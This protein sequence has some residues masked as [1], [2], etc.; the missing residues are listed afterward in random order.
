ML[1]EARLGIEQ[2]FVDRC[3]ARAAAAP[4]CRRS[5]PG[6]GSRWRGRRSRRRR[7]M[8]AASSSASASVRG[9]GARRQAQRAR[10]LRGL[11]FGRTARRDGRAQFVAHA[12]AH[13]RGREHDAR[14]P[15][16]GSLPAGSCGDLQCEQPALVVRLEH[17]AVAVGRA[18]AVR[19]REVA[20]GAAARR[21]RCGRRNPTAPAR[22]SSA[23]LRGGGVALE[24]GAEGDRVG[25][26]QAA[27]FR[28]APSSRTGRSCRRRRPAAGPTAGPGRAERAGTAPSAAGTPCASSRPAVRRLARG[29]RCGALKPI[30][31]AVMA[32]NATAMA[33]AVAMDC[34]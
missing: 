30:S 20:Q 29:A 19:G 17:H 33:S 28:R 24:F 3:P 9:I 14:R 16:S 15:C 25:Q 1:A 31:V 32:N 23:A 10:E 11:L 6:A 13:G 27:R 2:E 34:V 4:A 22:A 7:A 26:R 5:V 18:A 21:S 12:G 8:P